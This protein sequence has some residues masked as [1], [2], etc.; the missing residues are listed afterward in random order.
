MC[1]YH[2]VGFTDNWQEEAQPEAVRRDN[3]DVMSSGTQAIHEGPRDG[4]HPLCRI[5]DIFS[6]SDNPH[7]LDVVHAQE[8]TKRQSLE[9]HEPALTQGGYGR[10]VS[11][12]D[13]TG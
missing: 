11:R 5:G 7:T 8:S 10:E 2:C 6:H 3:R 1:E 12:R 9:D 4:L 13:L